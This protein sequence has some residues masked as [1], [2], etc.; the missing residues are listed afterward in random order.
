METKDALLKVIRPADFNLKVNKVMSVR[1]NGVRIKALS[2]DLNKLMNSKKLETAGLK[3]EPEGRANPRP[4]I[5]VPYGL[6]RDEIKSEIIA[7]NLKEY[8]ASDI[9]VYV[10]RQKDRH[11]T[12]SCVIE[13]SPEI[14]ALLMRVKQVFVGYSAC[15]ISD[16]VRVLQCYKYLAF[17][18]LARHCRGAPRCG[19][20][21]SDHET[22]NCT[23]RNESMQ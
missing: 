17:G 19:H 4:L 13:A 2:V 8:D 21:S 20:C 10:F 7:L 9:K 5:H 16:Y 23:K 15:R 14:R 22:K 6:S 12:V 11:N 3:I 1:N 18:H